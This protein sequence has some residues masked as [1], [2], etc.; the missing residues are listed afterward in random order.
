MKTVTLER[1]EIGPGGRRQWGWYPDR[2]VVLRDVRMV[3]A[4]GDVDVT[5]VMVGTEILTAFRRQ[6]RVVR[7]GQYVTI[8]VEN[9]DRTG[10]ACAIELDVEPHGP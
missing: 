3:Q 6:K 9:Q 4:E 7:P 1:Q 5:M 10:G 8:V 2:T